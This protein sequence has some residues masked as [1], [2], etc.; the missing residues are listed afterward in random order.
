MQSEK[1]KIRSRCLGMEQ[2]FLYRRARMKA[3]SKQRKERQLLARYI[4]WKGKT[5]K[6][7]KDPFLSIA[8]TCL[9]LVPKKRKYRLHLQNQKHKSNSKR[10]IY[11]TSDIPLESPLSMARGSQRC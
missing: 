3:R 1:T 4:A 7:L 2:G 11:Q 5:Q 9:S 10:W 6:F 8:R